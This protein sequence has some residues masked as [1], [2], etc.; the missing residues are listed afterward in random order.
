MLYLMIAIIVAVV[1]HT[2][3]TL[4]N[5]PFRIEF[6][7][8]IIVQQP[9]PTIVDTEATEA[10]VKVANDKIK[11]NIDDVIATLNDIMLGSEGV[12]PGGER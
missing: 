7:K 5:K 10:E 11:D 9:A 2:V 6:K 1:A 8:T 3:L 12:R 4:L